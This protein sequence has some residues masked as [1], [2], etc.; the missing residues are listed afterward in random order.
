MATF[1]RISRKAD[2][3]WSLA[4]DSLPPGRMMGRKGAT[5]VQGRVPR[6]E[7]TAC[8]TMEATAYWVK[9]ASAEIS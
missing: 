7:Q 8:D 5:C 9:A 3:E 1:L 2:Y 6:V 4:D